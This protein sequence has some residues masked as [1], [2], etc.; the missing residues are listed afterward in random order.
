MRRLWLLVAVISLYLVQDVGAVCPTE[1]V[2]VRGYMTGEEC[3]RL[4]D[5][6]LRHHMSGFV[7]GLFIAPFFGAPRECVQPLEQCFVGKT[8]TQLEAVMRK[9]LGEHPER[10]HEACNFLAYA[11]ISEMC[12]LR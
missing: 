11:A 3:Y 8:D 2:A 4:P 12:Q 5:G 7:N 10:W 9:W 1:T 6:V